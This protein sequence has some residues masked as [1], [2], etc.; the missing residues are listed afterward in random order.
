[1]KGKKVDMP[2]VVAAVVER[3]TKETLKCKQDGRGRDGQV[4]KSILNPCSSFQ[5]DPVFIPDP[6]FSP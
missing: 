1:M 2:M 4:G 5:L 6:F 3:T